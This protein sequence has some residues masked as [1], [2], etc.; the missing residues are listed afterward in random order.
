M[1]DGTKYSGR[2][3]VDIDQLFVT[4]LFLVLADSLELK[5]CLWR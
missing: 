3:R 1:V 4:E 2:E 5:G